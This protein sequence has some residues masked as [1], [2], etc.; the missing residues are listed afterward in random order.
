MMGDFPAAVLIFVESFKIFRGLR[1]KAFDEIYAHST[2]LEG[3][4]ATIEN[5][6]VPALLS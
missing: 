6:N 3:L 5:L 4:G 2:W 1:A